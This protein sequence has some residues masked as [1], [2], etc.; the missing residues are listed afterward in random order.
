MPGV[1]V[2]WLGHFDLTQ[3][4]G[5]SRAVPASAIIWRGSSASSR[6]ASARQG[7]GFLATDDD[8]AREYEANGFRMFAYGVDQRMLQSALSH[9]L[10]Y[11]AKRRADAN[12]DF[13]STG[14][15][16][17]RATSSTR[18]ASPRSA[19]RRWRSS[20]PRRASSGNTCPKS[21][22]E[23]TAEHAARYDALYVNMARVPAARGR[24]ARLPAARRRAPRRRLRFGRRAGDDARRRPRD[25]YADRR[26][27]ARSRRSRSRS[28]SRSP[29]S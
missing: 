13:M 5:H 11:S 9:G 18:A 27:R 17:S 3:L 16:A 25:Q 23:I 8:W 24:R 14:A 10:D 7:R 26:C 20:T 19:A 22:R 12:R 6:R 2:L 28:S 21:C 15:S 4:H 1:D 29:A